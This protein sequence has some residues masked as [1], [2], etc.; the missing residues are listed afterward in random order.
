MLAYAH[1][2]LYQQFLG[3]TLVDLQAPLRAA[4][5]AYTLRVLG[6]EIAMLTAA[7]AAVAIV[8][9]IF[10]ARTNERRLAATGLLSYGPVSIYGVAIVLA[11]AVGWE[12]DVFVMS[13]FD[14]TEAETAAAIAEAL[15]FVLQPLAWGRLG[16]TLAAAVVFAVL[17]VRLCG[18]PVIRAIAAAIVAALCAAAVQFTVLGGLV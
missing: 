4:F 16:A 13:A 1:F 10:P 2:L 12:P 17:Q 3:R 7:A 8:Q 9:R 15:P 18:L 5:T 14:A 6:A 11:T